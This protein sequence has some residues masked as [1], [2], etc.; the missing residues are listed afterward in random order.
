MKRLK[1]I[2]AWI[3]NTRRLLRKEIQSPV[4]VPF[5]KRMNPFFTGFLSEAPVIY[6]F[7]NHQ[8]RLYLSD[9]K[10]FVKTPFINLDF[11][12]LLDNKLV[13]DRYFSGMANII[14]GE[15][16]IHKGKIY[17]DNDLNDAVKEI[18]HMLDTGTDLVIKPLSGGGGHGILF[19]SPEGDGVKINGTLFSRE[20]TGTRISSLTNR[21]FYKRFIQQGFSH[22]IFP[23]SLNTIRMI[24]MISPETGLP[25]IPLAV[26]RFGT[27][28]SRHVDNWSS[29]GL[30]A[31]I[32]LDTGILGKAVAYPEHGR[33][34]WHS[35]H[36]DTGVEIEGQK[37]PHWENLKAEILSL[38]EKVSMIPYIGWDIVL[39]GEEISI[40][41]ANT[42]SDV[43]L[44][45][46]HT[47]LLSL[48]GVKE[49]FTYHKIL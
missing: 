20:E 35:S 25:F 27:A 30:S 19:L 17:R 47:P 11:G 38:A 21:I 39:S 14:P 26:H 44:L 18:F 48:P 12:Y 40:L 1:K 4:P 6:D 34:I 7:K 42:N 10:R 37:I 24:T 43:N 15:G 2:S 36:P 9:Y 23:G 45:Q 29:G 46:V 31:I 33:L 5:Y 8:R 32:D 49:F 41:E 13:F 28:K 3:N 22:R 16:L